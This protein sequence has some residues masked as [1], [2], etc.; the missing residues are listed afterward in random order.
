MPLTKEEMKTIEYDIQRFRSLPVRKGDWT[1]QTVIEGDVIDYLK[2][3]HMEKEEVAK[4][5]VSKMKTWG[6]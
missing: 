6:C 5:I 1:Y 2:N 3:N 4:E